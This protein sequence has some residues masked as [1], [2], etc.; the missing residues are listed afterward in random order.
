MGTYD[1]LEVCDMFE[2]RPINQ[3]QA[4]IHGSLEG[5]QADEQ[6]ENLKVTKESHWKV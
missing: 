6:S 2:N 4:F 5:S 3:T 1:N